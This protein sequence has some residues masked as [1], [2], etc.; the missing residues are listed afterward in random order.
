MR[1]TLS[2]LH[3]Y[4]T[5]IQ[6][7][8]ASDQRSLKKIWFG[9]FMEPPLAR[10]IRMGK[11]QFSVQDF[12]DAFMF[13]EF[14]SMILSQGVILCSQ[15]LSLGTPGHAGKNFQIW[16]TLSY[17]GPNGSMSYKMTCWKGFSPDVS[18]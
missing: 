15:G 1:E 17:L 18:S 8:S 16:Q 10:S 7:P 5:W 14:F 13:S 6:L 4:E 12:C 11:E 3:F 9:V 2:N